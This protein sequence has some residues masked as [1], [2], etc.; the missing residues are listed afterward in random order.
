MNCN[1]CNRT[2]KR[3]HSY[4]FNASCKCIEVV[5][6]NHKVVRS[7][8]TITMGTDIVFMSST[9]ENTYYYSL[10]TKSEYIGYPIMP[11][12]IDNVLQTKEYIQRI[13]NIISL[14]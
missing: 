6:D 3:Q 11:N 9:T 2:V 8:L 4:G 5:L 10:N 12:I 14:K 7:Y 13:K 1:N